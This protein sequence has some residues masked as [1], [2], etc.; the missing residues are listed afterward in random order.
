MRRFP[1]FLLVLFYMGCVTTADGWRPLFEGQ[2]MAGWELKAVHGGQGGVWTVENG[3]LVANQDSDHRGG[4]LGTTENFSDFEIELEFQA[5]YPV[6]SGLFLR[7]RPD[8]MGYQVTIDYKEG[9]YVGSLYAPAAGGFIDQYPGW[10]QAYREDGWNHLR[11]RIAG[12]PPHV[13]AW[14]NGVQTL[15]LHDT[16]ERYPRE[17]YVGLQ[18]HGGAGSWGADSRARFRNVRIR[19]LN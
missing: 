10:Q 16:E 2:S 6:D 11:A 18:V 5:D 1:G 7:T 19:A 15:D 17:G 12:Q 14:L 4:L 3:A 8:G 13:Q 9:G